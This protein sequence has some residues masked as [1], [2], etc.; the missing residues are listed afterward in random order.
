MST[1]YEKLEDNI[2]DAYLLNR[3]KWAVTL[4]NAKR[5][6]ALMIKAGLDYLS[7][8]TEG[9]LDFVDASNPATL[10]MEFSSTLAANNFRYFKAADKKHYPILA[11]RMED[12]YPHMSLT[13]YEGM[14]TVPT[15]AKF[16]LGYRV[17]DILKL[18]EKS[19]IDGIRKIMIPRGTLL[20]VDGTDFTTLHPIEIRVNDFDSSRL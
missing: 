5:N 9:R 2:S 6:P 8:E 12:L 20:Q 17:V 10:L 1:N 16:V 7:D 14:Y 18:A 15:R 11:T 3:Q 4:E 13:L 19:D